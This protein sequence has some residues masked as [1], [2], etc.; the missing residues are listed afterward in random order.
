MENFFKK[1]IDFFGLTGLQ[2]KWGT[3]RFVLESDNYVGEI[4]EPSNRVLYI[5]I[6]MTS[7]SDINEK[8][9][10]LNEKSMLFLFYRDPEYLSELLTR[11]DFTSYEEKVL[12]FA[13]DIASPETI[14]HLNQSIVHVM[15]SYTILKPIVKEIEDVEYIR[16]ATDV[17][18]HFRE[19]RD[20][21][22][23]MVGNNIS[24]TLYG[25]KNRLA[26][27]PNYVKNIGY[28]ELTKVATEHYKGKP[29]ILVAS[30]P[31][32]DKNV[33]LL[34]DYQDKALILACDGS[35]STLFKH[36][37][38]PHVVGSVERISKTYE[39]FY[40]HRKE[41]LLNMDIIFSGPAVV[42]PE[43]VDIFKDQ[44]MISAFKAHEGYG[45]WMDQI[46]MNKKGR[47]WSGTSVAHFLYSF[48]EGL[49]CDPIIL[50]GQD[51][52][53]S[54]SGLSHA[55][56]VEI[57]ENV[58]LKNVETWVEGYDGKDIPS[59]SVWKM[60]LLTLEEIVR[61]SPSNAIDAT[62]GGALI[63]GTE[64]MPLKEALESY[65]KETLPR[66]SEFTKAY[67]C[68]FEYLDKVKGYS[69]SKIEAFTRLGEKLLK[70]IEKGIELNKKAS[71]R[72]AKGID[73][74][75]QLDKIYDAME[76]VD[77]EIVKYIA[78]EP[79]LMM[80]F[81]YPIFAASRYINALQSD[82][83]TL[84]T[85]KLNLE[86][87]AGMLEV[88]ELYSK[89]F[90]YLI[91]EALNDLSDYYGDQPSYDKF[92]QKY[93]KKHAEILDDRNYKTYYF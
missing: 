85:I 16:L 24:D 50:V 11:I 62:E 27:M 74:Q 12:F 13:G 10:N 44:K 43:I 67:E 68:D 40:S 42:R 76:Y 31:S 89:K 90:V 92:M 84:E 3:D 14:I 4:D 66:V 55:G 56:D 2:E 47:V 61:N 25:L 17:I 58:E 54:T 29:A 79:L 21:Y 34:K 70:K 36:G 26:N 37:I 69:L 5:G 49:G 6:E 45:I 78:T 80:L 39:A 83:Y 48:A 35:L 53:Y 71:Q 9:A 88:M 33:H 65:C 20:N 18:K 82:T 64:I 23:F 38:I 52:A 7:L 59:T 30:G 22:E 93:Y 8:L 28:S 60:F 15:F 57:I 41:E 72:V 1:N 19:Y 63:K 51:L 46:T 32:L 75:E 81:Q 77:N 86:L 87:H 91:Y 73:R